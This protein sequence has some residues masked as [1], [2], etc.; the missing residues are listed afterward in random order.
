MADAIRNAPKSVYAEFVATCPELI[1]PDAEHSAV[2]TTTSVTASAS[3]WYSKFDEPLATVRCLLGNPGITF[4]VLQQVIA[5][6]TRR[7]NKTVASGPL[8][9]SQVIFRQAQGGQRKT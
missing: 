9:N 3:G 1:S 8:K 7:R 4:R 2:T 5:E 6:L